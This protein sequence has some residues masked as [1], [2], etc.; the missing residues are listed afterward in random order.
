M[1]GIRPQEPNKAKTGISAIY[2]D[3]SEIPTEDLANFVMKEEL[4]CIEDNG[5]VPTLWMNSITGECWW[6]YADP[7]VLPKTQEQHI[8]ELEQVVADLAML[9]VPLEV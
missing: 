6:E 2:Y 1:L 5:L 3:V 8:A 4:P 7:P 9:Q